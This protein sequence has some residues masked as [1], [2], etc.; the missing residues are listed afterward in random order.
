MQDTSIGV[1]GEELSAFLLA[2]L[3]YRIRERNFRCRFGEI[4]LIAERG[5]YLC[6]VEVK[7]RGS[8]AVSQPRESITPRK[9]QKLI[10][11]A[12]YYLNGHAAE[13]KK[14]NLQPRFD[15]VEVL[16]SEEGP[17]SIRLL[18]NVF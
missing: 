9:Q 1:L 15:C 18:K 12:K 16:F 2:D 10:L 4:D 14:R 17:C 6:F 5:K 8:G 7:S 3:G 11:T 13:L